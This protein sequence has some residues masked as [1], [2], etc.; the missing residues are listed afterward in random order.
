LAESQQA[1]RVLVGFA[2]RLEVYTERLERETE[3]LERGGDDDD[4]DG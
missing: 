3:R 2:A 4:D 1:L